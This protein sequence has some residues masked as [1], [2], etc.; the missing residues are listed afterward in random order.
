[1]NNNP[2]RDR[3]H[4]SDI[5]KLADIVQQNLGPDFA[6]EAR[7]KGAFISIFDK[8]KVFIASYQWVQ[9]MGWQP[10]IMQPFTFCPDDVLHMVDELKRCI[11]GT[12]ETKS[13]W[14]DF[15]TV[16]TNKAW[17]AYQGARAAHAFRMYS[18]DPIPL[19]IVKA[20]MPL[21]GGVVTPGLNLGEFEP[22]VDPVE[23]G[24]K[25]I[26]FPPALVHYPVKDPSPMDNKAEP[27]PLDWDLV[28]AS[29]DDLLKDME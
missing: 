7:D 26:P 8:E 6:V 5:L 14:E 15:Q 3:F 13:R 27:D 12:A 19:D 29:F 4:K 25:G 20:G 10:S 11:Q 17:Q 21:H 28:D 9:G 18:P 1:M 23:A 16:K 2:E 24:P 22:E